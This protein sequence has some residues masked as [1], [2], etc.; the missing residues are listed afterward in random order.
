MIKNLT[1]KQYFMYYL[2]FINFDNIITLILLSNF[3]RT[4]LNK[5]NYYKYIINFI[6]LSIDYTIFCL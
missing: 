5:K 1:K 2:S 3:I 6:V 4:K